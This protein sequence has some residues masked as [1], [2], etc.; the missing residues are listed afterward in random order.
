MSKTRIAALFLLLAAVGAAAFAL[1]RGGR[2]ERL[3]NKPVLMLLT[4]LPLV[5]GEEFGLDQKGSAMFVALRSRYQVVAVDVTDPA[6][7]AKGKLLMMAQPRAQTA[8]NLVALDDWVRRGGRVLLFADPLLEWPS[9]KALGDPTRPPAMFAD[10]GLLGHWGLRLDAPDQHGPVIRAIGGNKVLTASPGSLAGTCAID[11]GALAA[12]CTVGKGKA[13]VVA[14]AD[15]LD[16]E[17][18]GDGAAGN[19]EAV[20]AQ[21]DSVESR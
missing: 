16:V 15:L 9:G 20:L 1:A 3:G 11:R 17:G 7:L 21:L 14:D 10:T 12:R 13:I 18:L 4:S 6:A 5:F 2:E 19:A 8:D